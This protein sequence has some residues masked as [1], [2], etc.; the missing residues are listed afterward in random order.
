MGINWHRRRTTTHFKSFLLHDTSSR[1]LRIPNHL[2]N[3]TKNVHYLVVVWW[4]VPLPVGGSAHS[5]ALGLGVGCITFRV[6][7]DGSLSCMLAIFFQIET[8]MKLTYSWC[9]TLN[10]THVKR[11][12]INHLIFTMLSGQCF[13]FLFRQG[14][15]WPYQGDVNTR[16]AIPEKVEVGGYLIVWLRSICGVEDWIDMRSSVP[17]DFVTT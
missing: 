8:S 1:V 5:I 16:E 7:M 11:Y 4:N 15:E 12:L 3:A 6:M 17:W 9:Q 13:V 14:T 2:S 10:V